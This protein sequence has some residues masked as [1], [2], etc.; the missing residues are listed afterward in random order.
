MLTKLS[1]I[2][3]SSKLLFRKSLLKIYFSFLSVSDIQFKM[4]QE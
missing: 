3:E 1:I 4:Q 2:I